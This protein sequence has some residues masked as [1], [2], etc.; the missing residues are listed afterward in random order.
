[1]GNCKIGR[2]ITYVA[3]DT[4]PLLIM[5]LISVIIYQQTYVD[6]CQIMFELV[7]TS[8]VNTSTY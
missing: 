4:Y 6:T 8:I 3:E 7:H 1:M 5:I 2:S